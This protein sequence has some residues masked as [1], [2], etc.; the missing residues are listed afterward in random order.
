MKEINL[1]DYYPSFYAE[2][3]LVTVSDEVAGFLAEDKRRQINYAQYIRDHKAFYSLDVCGAELDAITRPEQPDEA[4]ER[5]ERDEMLY[6]ALARLT[7]KQRQ[8][9]IDYI[10][11]EYPQAEIA[12]SERVGK[13]A[14]SESVT[15]GLE[16][17]KEILKNFL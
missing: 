1:R 12:R 7:P 10:M 4:V 3:M 2:D 11:A 9:I 14:V 16:K 13:S 5:R 6:A 17:L 8:R 15:R